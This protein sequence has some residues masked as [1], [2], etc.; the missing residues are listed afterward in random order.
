MC[1]CLIDEETAEH[2]FLDVF[3]IQIKELNYSGTHVTSIPLVL[4]LSYRAK[5]HCL[6]R[7]TL[8]FFSMSKYTFNLPE[9][10][11]EHIYTK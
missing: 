1:D 10:L 5:K 9:D 6:M 7:I 11:L 4:L 2:Y 8:V 3:A